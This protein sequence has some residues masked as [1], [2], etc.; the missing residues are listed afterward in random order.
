MDEPLTPLSDLDP[1]FTLTSKSRSQHVVT[2]DTDLGY[3]D[4]QEHREE[5]EVFF[6]D[7]TDLS[8]GAA[9]TAAKMAPDLARDFH[10]QLNLSFSQSPCGSPNSTGGS[11]SSQTSSPMSP[12][13]ELMKLKQPPM[14]RIHKYKSMS[15]P[16]TVT[17]RKFF[18]RNLSIEEVQ[19]S[20]SNP[21]AVDSLESERDHAASRRPVGL[22]TLKER[23]AKHSRLRNLLRPLRRS[24]SAG[25]SQDNPAYTLFLKHELDKEKQE[26]E[27]A[28]R[29]KEKE[30]QRALVGLSPFLHG[31]FSFIKLF[32]LCFSA[33]FFSS[34]FCLFLY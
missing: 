14:G 22:M 12:G 31:Y 28:E 21:C 13:G 23:E 19:R 29:E 7:K 34:F 9:T 8:L 5:S 11:T 25:C 33:Y 15:P 26:K 10:K 20:L 32:I 24:H 6:T 30:R 18:S 16:V 1:G 3:A 2:M 4:L 17:D 27:K